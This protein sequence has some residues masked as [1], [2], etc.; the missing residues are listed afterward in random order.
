GSSASTTGS[1]RAA[2]DGATPIG[3][4]CKTCE[5]LTCPQRAT[6]ELQV[7]PLWLLTH[8]DAPKWW[9]GSAGSR[10][11][12]SAA[13]SGRRSA[14]GCA[15]G[16]GVDVPVHKGPHCRRPRRNYIRRRRGRLLTLWAGTHP[17]VRPRRPGQRKR[18]LR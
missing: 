10:R 6:I 2:P 17:T 11:P 5:R 9:P 12:A 18:P 7:A 15:G 3:P 13:G 4:G 16:Q 8:T 14:T 1:C